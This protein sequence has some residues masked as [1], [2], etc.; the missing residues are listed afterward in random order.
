MKRNIKINLMLI[1][2]SIVFLSQDAFSSAEEEFHKTITIPAETEVNVSNVNGNIRV[3]GWDEDYVDIYALKTTKLGQDELDRVTIDVSVNGVVDIVTVTRKRE[4]SNDS[5]FSRIFGE[6]ISK[7]PKVNVE[8]T[9]KLPMSVILANAS[10][11]NGNVEVDGTTGD[12]SLRTTNGSVRVKNT[13]G[14]IDAKSTN[15]NISITEGAVAISARTTNGS[16]TAAI[17]D[18]I[19]DETNISTTNGSITLYVTKDINVDIELRTVNG[20]INLN[21]ISMMVDNFSKRSVSGT[22]G[23]GGKSISARTVNGS[24]SLEEQ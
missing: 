16:I 2:L 11:T 5:F 1:L 20:G 22:L 12:S 6:F 9:I 7:S 23:S 15:G 10:S 18:D 8:Y 19:M 14:F 4:D 17:S 21:D 3:L 24:I 13:N